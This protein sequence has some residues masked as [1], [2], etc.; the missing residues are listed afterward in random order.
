M[1]HIRDQLLDIAHH[2]LDWEGEL[3]RGALMDSFD[4]LQLMTLVIAVEDRFRIFL[5]PEDEERIATID[6][7]I[8]VIEAKRHG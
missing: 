6:D 4:S 2:E 1:N 8:D 3:P 7:L 5:E